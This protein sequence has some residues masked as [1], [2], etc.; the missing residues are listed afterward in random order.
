MRRLI[1]LIIVLS[2]ALGGCA[3]TKLGDAF[4]VLTGATVGVNNPVTPERLKFA[5][6]SAT[7]AF[8]GLNAYKRSCVNRTIP[9]SCRTVIKQLQVYTSKIP[10]ALTRLRAFVRNNDQ[11]NAVDAYNTVIGLINDFKSTAATNNVQVQ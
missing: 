7:V 3:G 1:P 8:A 6:D 10:N 9:A 5:E 4:G 2:V 11:V